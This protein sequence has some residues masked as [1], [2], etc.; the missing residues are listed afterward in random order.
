VLACAVTC[1]TL[2]KA[3][4]QATDQLELRCNIASQERVDAVVAWLRRHSSSTLKHISLQD[5]R[6][7]S[8]G[9]STLPL[10]WESITQLT[11]LTLQGFCVEGTGCSITTNADNEQDY[12]KRNCGLCQLSLLK[13]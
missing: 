7:C 2:C 9:A 3:A 6:C 1:R 12:S 10:P 13:R 8:A 11:S 5:S 4:G